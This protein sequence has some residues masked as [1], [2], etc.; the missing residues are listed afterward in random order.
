MTSSPFSLQ[1]NNQGREQAG[2]ARALLADLQSQMS[3]LNKLA[4]AT[5]AERSADLDVMTLLATLAEQWQLVPK[6]HAAAVAA[7]APSSA[8]PGP[9]LLEHEA[10]RLGLSLS[11]RQAR[12]GDLQASDLPCIMLLHDGGGRLLLARDAAAFTAH[13]QHGH[14]QIDIA[15]LA[16]NAAGTVLIVRPATTPAGRENAEP[17]RATGTAMQ[18]MSPGQA[19]RA[20]GATIMEALKRQRPLLV[21]LIMA[22]III[23]LFSML[24]PLFSMAVF[25]RVIP[26]A[27][28]ETLWA[29]ALGVSVALMLEFALRQA[30]LRLFDAAS[31]SISQR[32]QGRI[33]GRLL[34]AR[35]QDL[36]RGSGA[37]VQPMQDLDQMA[38]LAPQ[39]VIGLLVDLP[40]FV[41]LVCL[42]AY[43]SGP[44]AFAP[45]TGALILLAMHIITHRLAHAAID[46]HSGFQRRQQQ[47]VIDSVSAHE[48][49]R[50]T[51]AGRHVLARWDVAADAAGYAA[52]QTRYWHGLA[53]QGGAILVQAV[54]VVTLV[55]GVYRIDAALM[56]IGALSASILLVNRAMMPISIVTSL[57]FRALQLLQAAAPITTIMNAELEAGGDQR[58]IAAGAVKGQIDAASLSFSYPGE[59]RQSLQNLNFSIRPGEKVGIIGK[60]GCGKSTLLRLL[61]RLHE[62]DTGRLCLDG[63]DMR[64]FDPAVI[65]R[66]IGY[67]P[68]D[69]HL[70]DATLEHNLTLGLDEV[71][72]G[73]LERIAKITGVHEFANLHPSGFSLQVGPGGMRLSGGE[74]QAVALARALMGRPRLVVLDEPTAAFDNTAEARL[75]GELKL[76]L[77][78]TGLIVA[79]HRLAVLGLV[80]RII[81]MDGG[82]IVADGPKS[83]IFAKFGLAA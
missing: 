17:T 39:L 57:V 15:T 41:V 67:M 71:P 81:W 34:G 4:E 78:E 14:R 42:I 55:I 26:H 56:T 19:A 61:L 40:F 1:P 79:T 72:T 5:I 82:R 52:H 76:H 20:L 36:P 16:A 28:M 60:A 65:R 7:R 59:Q 77:G 63:R 30:R 31:Q 74:R 13:G 69:T 35:T 58:H 47:L 83:E 44:V 24:L 50:I 9:A 64:Q 11:F 6:G 12:P 29:L 53:A 73:E 27:A 23:N 32:L 68:Q 54:M 51:G 33:M 37:A 80:D 66:A 25:D 48:R 38:Q 49:I 3:G 10:D 62:A 22:S 2:H 45:I 8:H 70:M 43:I 46:E 75:I 21:Q 18:A